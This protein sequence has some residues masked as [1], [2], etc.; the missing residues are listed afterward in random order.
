MLGR[1]LEAWIEAELPTLPIESVPEEPRGPARDAPLPPQTAHNHTFLPGLV[2][3][4]ANQRE[5]PLKRELGLSSA[6]VSLVYGASR[7]EGGVEGPLVGYLISRFGPKKLIICGA[8]LAGIGFL[9]LSRINSFCA[10]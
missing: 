10:S 4:Y 3:S 5:L 6:A 9:L 7:L 8:G 1:G 2:E